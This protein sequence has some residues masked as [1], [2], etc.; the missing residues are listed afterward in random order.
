MAKFLKVAVQNLLD[1]GTD[2]TGT[3]DKLTVASTA[4]FTIGDYVHNT[5]DGTYAT[6]TAIDS[7]TVA[8]ISEDI[9]DAAE[10]YAVYSAT[11]STERLMS[12]EKFLLAE[13]PSPD[14]ATFIIGTTTVNYASGG[15]DIVTLT[16][17][18]QAELLTGVAE[19]V[20]AGL[21][22]AHS[23]NNRPNTSGLISLPTGIAVLNLAIA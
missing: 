20:E 2:A 15:T 22:L 13:Q 17:V 19:A 18:P 21:E 1:S 16:H 11:E 9:M 12:A 23:N 8:S 3:A 6:I 4:T 10:T 14:A 7:G 5:S